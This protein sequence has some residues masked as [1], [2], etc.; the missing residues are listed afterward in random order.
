MIASEISSEAIKL[1]LI[2][3]I[4]ARNPLSFPKELMDT[5]VYITAA[6]VILSK[7]LDCYTTR[8]RING[9]IEKERNAFAR[10]LM[11]KIGITPTIWLF[12]VLTIILVAL[13]LWLLFYVYPT[14]LHKTLFIIVAV[15]I[16]VL[17]L[18]VAH[19]NYYNR[20]NKVTRFLHRRK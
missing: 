12:F 4:F 14:F 5:L 17:Q 3:I 9:E 15:I 8:I 7:L 19:S 1:Q 13:A 11:R 6:A 10:S 16:S 18:G 2:K 20:P